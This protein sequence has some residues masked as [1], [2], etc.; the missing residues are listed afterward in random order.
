MENVCAVCDVMEMCVWLHKNKRN[1]TAHT[2][3]VM[4]SQDA[5]QLSLPA[6]KQAT[7]C[8]TFYCSRYNTRTNDYKRQPNQPS[9]ANNSLTL[10]CA[11]KG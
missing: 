6:R 1:D 7:T 8:Y 5:C 4:R 10:I 9:F 3:S 2:F 11:S